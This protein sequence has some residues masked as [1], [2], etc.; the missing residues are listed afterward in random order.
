MLPDRKIENKNPGTLAYAMG[1]YVRLL[2]DSPYLKRPSIKE[3]KALKVDD[4]LPLYKKA[5][6]YNA[7]WHFVGHE[8]AGR[9]K[10]LL[11]NTLS[12]ANNKMETPVSYQP[13][14]IPEGN[15]IY[16][17]HDKKAVQSQVRFFVPSNNYTHSPA[18]DARVSAFNEYMDGGFSGLVMQEIREFRSLAYATSGYFEK[19]KLSQKPL[20]FKAYIGCQADK[21][22]EAIEVML[23]LI[24]NMPVKPERIRPIQDLLTNSTSSNYPEFRQVSTTIDHL[25]QRGFNSDPFEA[26]ATQYEQL[27]SEDI[28]NFYKNNL[29]DKPIQ[30][31]IYG[32]LAKVDL[33]KLAKIGKLVKLDLSDIIVK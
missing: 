27:Q 7:V 19:P 2:K 6:T 15:T 31:C 20:E 1:E 21:T 18:F 13:I 5:V 28:E 29:K 3:L 24:Q 11:L 10:E 4:L 16:L 26:E 32:N 14:R 22:N 23:G 30:I 9:V 17:V 33:A 12:M 8:P 25:K